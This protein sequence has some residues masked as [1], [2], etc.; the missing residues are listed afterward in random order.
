V[1][2][3]A[4]ARAGF[5]IK[6]AEDASNLISLAARLRTADADPRV[7][8]AAVSPYAAAV[9]DLDGVMADN[10]IGADQAR[11]EVEIS[12][13]KAAAAAAEA[14]ALYNSVLVLRA[15]QAQALAQAA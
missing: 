14:P 3:P 12:V 2:L 6:T 7:K 10:G 5:P 13:K 11:Q 8:Q 9:S 1:F 4:V 15:A